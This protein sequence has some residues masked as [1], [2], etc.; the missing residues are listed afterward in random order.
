MRSVADLNEI[1][2]IKKYVD[3]TNGLHCKHFLPQHTISAGLRIRTQLG[4]MRTLFV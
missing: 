1:D 2:E 4:K 3:F